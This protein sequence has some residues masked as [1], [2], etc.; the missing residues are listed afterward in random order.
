MR[1]PDCGKVGVVKGCTIPVWGWESY[2]VRMEDSGTRAAMRIDGV[3]WLF[4]RTPKGCVRWSGTC[5]TTFHAAPHG[6]AWVRHVEA[7]ISLH[8][9]MR[10]RGFYLAPNPADDSAALNTPS[11]ASNA[12][13]YDGCIAAGLVGIA[14]RCALAARQGQLHTCTV[15]A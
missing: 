5:P 7:H 9:R 4:G 6:A 15:W 10:W 14:M 2:R 1:F 8:R 13:V 11:A 3:C 12:P